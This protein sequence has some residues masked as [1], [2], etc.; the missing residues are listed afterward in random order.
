MRRGGHAAGAL[1]TA[2]AVA[3]LAVFLLLPQPPRLTLALSD[4]AGLDGWQE[5][6]TAAALAALL[7]S[8]AK[9]QSKPD[10]AVL[11]PL[12]K[13]FDFGP[14]AEWNDPCARAAAVP[15]HDAAAARRF[16]EEAFAPLR[17]GNGSD[18]DGLFTGY[19]EITLH[20]SRH[21]GGPYQTPLYRRPHDP[22]RYS[23]AEIDDGAL[24]GAGLELLWV[25]SPI[26]AFFLEI[27]GS[28]RVV[29]PDAS[30]VRVGYDGSNG[31]PYVPVGRLLIENGALRRDK[32]TMAAIRAWMEAHPGEGAALR[33]ENPSYVFFR[34][35]SQPGPLGAERVVLSAGRSLAV[36]RRFIALGVPLWLDARERYGAGSIRR[37]VVAQDA[38]GAIKGPVRGD[39]FWGH[40]A[41]AATG[42]G[43]MNARGRYWLLLPRA[44]ANRLIWIEA[45]AGGDAD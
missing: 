38:G 45:A 40:G 32:V 20:G 14:A 16:F 36:D 35:L 13:S 31:K 6:D 19:F 23:R 28:G 18:L 33:R 39:L 12:T 42:A 21:R 34:E 8:C 41:A 5:D 30:V 26:D 7:R 24:A 3:A 43:A 4:F 25:D 1:A 9:L 2:V 29:L 11:D 17:A 15:P 44:V 37:L 22:T 27:Q 10:A